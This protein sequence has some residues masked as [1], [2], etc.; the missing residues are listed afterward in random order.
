MESKL[1]FKKRGEN[2]WTVYKKGTDIFVGK[3]HESVISNRLIFIE[4]VNYFPYPN[5]YRQIADFCEQQ[6]KEE[7]G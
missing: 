7:E 1:E 3:V 4:S 6:T 5:D 2:L